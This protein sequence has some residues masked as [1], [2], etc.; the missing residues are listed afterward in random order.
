FS[1]PDFLQAAVR[2]RV[3]PA[4]GGKRNGRNRP[5]AALSMSD[6]TE[7]DDSKTTGTAAPDHAPT[8]TVLKML[9]MLNDPHGCRRTILF[10]QFFQQI[11]PLSEG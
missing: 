11:L 4:W 8:A 6:E 2:R 5:H 9:G 7:K 3:R 10:R 1:F